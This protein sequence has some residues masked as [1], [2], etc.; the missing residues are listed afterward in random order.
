MLLTLCAMLYA[1]AGLEAEMKT[2][3]NIERILES[4]GF[5]VTSECGPPRG[6]DA[7]V[8][9]RRGIAQGGGGCGKRYRQSDLGGENELLFFMHHPQGD[10]V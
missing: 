3:S 10:G 2:K 7:E 9:G 5:V 8:I 4:G 6:A 1:H